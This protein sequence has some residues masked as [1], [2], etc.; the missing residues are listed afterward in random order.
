MDLKPFQLHPAAVH[1]PIALLA[2]GLAVAGVRLRKSAPEWL[3]RAQSWLLWLG[4]LSAWA[5]L[6]LGLLA[7]ST[8]PHK[9]LAWEVLAD[10]ETLAWWTCSAFTALSGLRFYAV[11]KG[12]NDGKWRLGE[13]LFWLAA[14]VL[15]AATAWH[16]G[17]LVYKY[18]MGVVT[19]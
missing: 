2:A 10:H 8:A 5:A 11:R 3:S 19:E 1:F 15:L 16:G 7:E 9:P 17:E 18:G 6:S 12:R 4:T 13:F 14:F